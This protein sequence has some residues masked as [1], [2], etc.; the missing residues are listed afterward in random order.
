[1]EIQRVPNSLFLISRSQVFL[2]VLIPLV[3]NLIFSG[4]KT[5]TFQYRDI[6]SALDVFQKYRFCE[7]YANLLCSKMFL[8]EVLE[9]SVNFKHFHGPNLQISVMY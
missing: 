7:D 1:M 3:L 5:I 9:T 6:Q 4:L 2:I 8:L